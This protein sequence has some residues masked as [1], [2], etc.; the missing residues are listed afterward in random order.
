MKKQQILLNNLQRTFMPEK[1]QSNRGRKSKL[2]AHY[3]R[4]EKQF[5]QEFEVNQK[6]ASSARPYWSH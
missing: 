2:E 5:S 6:K 3:R 1:K 4:I